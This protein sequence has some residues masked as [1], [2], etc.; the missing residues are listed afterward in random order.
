MRAFVLLLDLAVL[1]LAYWL[2]SFLGVLIAAVLSLV[3]AGLT[4]WFSMARKEARES[5]EMQRQ[6]GRNT[7]FLSGLSDR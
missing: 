5:R 3:L 4:F 7:T 6:M 1:A 2:G